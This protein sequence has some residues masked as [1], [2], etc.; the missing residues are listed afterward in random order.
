MQ[1]SGMLHH[2]ALVRTDISE[3]CSTS[4]VFLHSIYRL[5]VTANVPGLPILITL[6]MEALRSSKTL[7]LN[8]S[9][10][11]IPKDSILHSHC[12]GNLKSYNTPDSYSNWG[13]IR[14][15]VTQGLMLGPVLFLLY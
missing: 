4:I 8:K 2:I 1:S 5:L 15:G 9:Q 11:N 14:H 10:H 12:H 6:M 3:E 13:M 7:V